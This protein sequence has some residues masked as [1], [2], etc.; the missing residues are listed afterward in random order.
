MDQGRI[1]HQG[2]FDELKDLEYFKTKIENQKYNERNPSNNETIEKSKH[3]TNKED[4]IKDDDSEI[5]EIVHR[6]STIN[7]D[8]N[9]EKI[10]VNWRTYA[11]LLFFNYWSF[12]AL[13]IL[14]VLSYYR[15][16]IKVQTNFYLIKWVKKVSKHH[17][18]D[19]EKFK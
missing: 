16:Q 3:D 17:V 11:R 7:N 2:H 13:I 1:I 14:L 12:V 8:E 9:K 5:S 10:K 15:V 6:G 19:H 18:N 4:H